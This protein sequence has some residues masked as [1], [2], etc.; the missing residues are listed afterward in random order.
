VDSGPAAP[1]TLAPARRE[2]DGVKNASHNTAQISNTA[3]PAMS[4]DILRSTMRAICRT[5]PSSR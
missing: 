1:A 5:T 2:R 3:S 4:A